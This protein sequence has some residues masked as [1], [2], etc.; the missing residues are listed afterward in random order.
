MRRPAE[1]VLMKRNLRINEKEKGGIGDGSQPNTHGFGC[2]PNPCVFF[3]FI[4]RAEQ[5]NVQ[6][7]MVS[8]R[9]SMVNFCIGTPF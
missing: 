4:V 5:V 3:F 2:E 8:D 6:R 9:R 7:C 1:P